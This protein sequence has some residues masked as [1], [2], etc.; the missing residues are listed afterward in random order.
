MRCR[1]ADLIRL[2]V[3]YIN[4]VLSLAK[5]IIMNVFL[6]CLKVSPQTNTIFQ[7]VP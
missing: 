1:T 2:N 4:A 6:T 3:V 7:V 5:A